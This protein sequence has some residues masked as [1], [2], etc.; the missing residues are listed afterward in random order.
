M[1]NGEE[2]ECITKQIEQVNERKR[3]LIENEIEKRKKRKMKIEKMRGGG[4]EKEGGKGRD[5]GRER[6]RSDRNGQI[7]KGKKK[8]IKEQRV[9]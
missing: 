7:D 1:E 2:E 4:R 5:R 9:K 6:E 3:D 8:G